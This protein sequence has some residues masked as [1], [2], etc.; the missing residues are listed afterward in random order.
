MTVHVAMPSRRRGQK[1]AYSFDED[2][3][4]LA[5]DAVQKAGLRPGAKIHVADLVVPPWFWQGTGLVQEASAS[6]V[7]RAVPTTLGPAVV[8]GPAGP[9]PD[10]E[11][12]ARQLHA[13]TPQ[14]PE[15]EWQK[16]RT[17]RDGPE[18][19]ADFPLGAYVL[20]ARHEQVLADRMKLGSGKVVSWT[21]IGAGAAPTEF[22]RLQ[23]AVGSYHVVL[24]EFPGGKRTVGIWS[25]EQ[26]PN[27]GQA[28]VPLLRR[29][30]RTQGAW[31]YGVKFGG[32]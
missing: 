13:A 27:V 8:V 23:E 14:R 19:E 20:P 5:W 21:T 22:Q 31:R 25:G 11:A 30:F 32:G 28:A 1:L 29:L 6:W 3:L 16:H 2:E 12:E 26:P 15:P 24:V 7:L 18:S 17:A 9:A 10:I 4:S